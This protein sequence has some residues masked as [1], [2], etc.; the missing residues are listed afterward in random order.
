MTTNNVEND[1]HQSRSWVDKPEFAAVYA[2]GQDVN[3]LIKE[4]KQ[5]GRC[6]RLD[7]IDEHI[8]YL[9]GDDTGYFNI[10]QVRPEGAYWWCSNGVISTRIGFAISGVIP[11]IELLDKSRK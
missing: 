1:V 11:K 4:W 2:E 10:L 5:E 7:T 9:V 8:R 6:M 3:Q